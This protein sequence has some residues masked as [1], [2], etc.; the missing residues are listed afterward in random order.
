ML[1]H[2]SSNKLT[3]CDV[4]LITISQ[5]NTWLIFR[6]LTHY[7]SLTSVKKSSHDVLRKTLVPVP[8]PVI[9]APR[10]SD[11]R[12]TLWVEKIYLN[13]IAKAS[14]H[15]GFLWIQSMFN[16]DTKNALFCVT[17]IQN[18]ASAP[19]KR[20]FRRG[21]FFSLQTG[22]GLCCVDSP[23]LKKHFCSKLLFQIKL[24]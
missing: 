11:A 4:V 3:G 7:V 9:Y 14:T 22:R 10:T 24:H 23:D 17:F 19:P 12:W 13:V 15:M 21:H 18:Y 2:L 1:L 8:W 20:A 16:V 6:R 5:L